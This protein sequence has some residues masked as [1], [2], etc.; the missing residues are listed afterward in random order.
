MIRVN[1]VIYGK[2][3]IGEPVL[4]E[5]INSRS[6]QRL[7]GVSQQGFPSGETKTTLPGYSRYVHSVGVMLLLRKLNA[8]M[9][10]Q[11]AGLL[12]DVSHTA[13]SHIIDWVVGDPTKE[14]YQD[15]MLETYIR[16]SE[17]PDIL[18]RYG[19]R[20]DRISRLE[21]NGHFGL[22][23]RK[24]P[25]LCADRLDYSLRDMRYWLGEDVTQMVNDLTVYKNEIVFSTK[26]SA[27]KFGRLYM[28]CQRDFWAGNEA[29]L[30]YHFISLALKEALKRGVIGMQDFYKDE[31][32]ILKKLR[33]SKQRGI[34]HNINMGLGRLRMSESKK[35]AIV[36]HK[37]F[38]YVDPKFFERGRLYRLSQTNI[39]YRNLIEEEKKRST[40]AVRVKVLE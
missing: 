29:R 24:I 12:H 5:L 40:G 23:E 31:S 21:N 11:I 38:R 4:V 7:K 1:D 16:N 36:L 20:T 8:N 39:G 37:K 35:G 15:S 22:L 34:I 9:E 19:Y 32:Y 28:K 6:V 27:T 18:S 10:E 26:R 13:F 17:I 2:F 33:G 30:R 3:T 25:D 14:D